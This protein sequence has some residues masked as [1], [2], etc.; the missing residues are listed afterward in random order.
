M[1]LQIMMIFEIVVLISAGFLSSGVISPTSTTSI[2][3]WAGDEKGS[4]FCSW[5]PTCCQIGG[6]CYGFLK[7]LVLREQVFLRRSLSRKARDMVIYSLFLIITLKVIRWEASICEFG[8]CH[9]KSYVCKR[10]FNI[11]STR[12]E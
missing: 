12:F 7:R 8:T 6:Q 4:R 5:E 2:A 1:W 9:I 3:S 10:N 11:V